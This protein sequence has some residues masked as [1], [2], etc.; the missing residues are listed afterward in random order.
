MKFF[1]GGGKMCT[2][3]H[4]S[5]GNRPK[6]APIYVWRDAFPKGPRSESN[7]LI[8]PKTEYTEWRCRK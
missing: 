5:S 2:P 7:L 3:L 4:S 8:C 1:K 6:A